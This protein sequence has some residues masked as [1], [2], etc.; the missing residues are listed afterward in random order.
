MMRTQVDHGLSS[1]GRGEAEQ[2]KDPA[3]MGSKNRNA[4]DA[5]PQ[6]IPELHQL[7]HK[8]DLLEEGGQSR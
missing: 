1:N 3:E 5:H 7:L 2:D 4:H 8:S 6:N